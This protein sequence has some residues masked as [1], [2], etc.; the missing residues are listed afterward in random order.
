[1][2]TPETS[3]SGNVHGMP[4]AATLGRGP[5]ALTQI[6]GFAPKMRPEVRSDWHP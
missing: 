6:G 1:M 3:P 5:D 4:F 2:N